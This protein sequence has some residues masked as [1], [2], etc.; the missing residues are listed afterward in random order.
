MKKS[1]FKNERGAVREV[2]LNSEVVPLLS[3][4]P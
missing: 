2:K 4:S 1:H 3:H